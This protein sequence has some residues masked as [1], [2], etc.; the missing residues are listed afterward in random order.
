MNSGMVLSAANVDGLKDSMEMKTKEIC[1]VAHVACVDF[2]FGAAEDSTVEPGDS[3]GANQSGT[4]NIGSVRVK[5]RNFL[6]VA[7]I[8]F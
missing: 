2:L 8:V 4:R 5:I 1:S 7:P 3:M 6:R